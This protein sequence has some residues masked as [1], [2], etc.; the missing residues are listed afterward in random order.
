V[1]G[2]EL[3]KLMTRVQRTFLLE[4]LVEK[5]PAK[6]HENLGWR[7]NNYKPIITISFMKKL[8]FLTVFVILVSGCIGQSPSNNDL[9]GDVC[10]LFANAIE[11]CWC[12]DIGP[13]GPIL[14]EAN[15]TI[16][17]EDNAKD[18]VMDYL[19]EEY[20]FTNTVELSGNFYNVFVEDSQG[21]EEV[22]TVYKDGTIFITIC[23]V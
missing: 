1:V 6:R 13:D 20:T 21:N 5:Y 11:S 19:D 12:N 17:S 7:T 8:I 16:E 15:T 4:R 3:A 14:L 18:I 22:Y 10:D 2:C 9:S 23:G